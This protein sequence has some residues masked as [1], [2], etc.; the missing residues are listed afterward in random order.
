MHTSKHLQYETRD[1]F[2]LSFR[3]KSRTADF[4]L[5]FES[6]A[7]TKM[8]LYKTNC[9]E[10]H[11]P[12]RSSESSNSRSFARPIR[13]IN[14]PSPCSAL[15][16]RSRWIIGLS[17]EYLKLGIRPANDSVPVFAFSC[18][19]VSYL[20]VACAAGSN[21][22][23]DRVQNTEKHPVPRKLIFPSNFLSFRLATDESI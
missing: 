10:L 7:R 15:V 6:K 17:I 22:D 3:D 12:A 21:L 9:S 19:R 18:F 23:L 8:L 2:F 13:V 14:N 1:V 16:A 11:S 20:R 5:H 4:T